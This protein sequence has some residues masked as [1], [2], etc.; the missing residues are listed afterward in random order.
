M[1]N[2]DYEIIQWFFTVICKHYYKLHRLQV[3]KQFCQRPGQ[4][5]YSNSQ[6]SHNLLVSLATS[7]RV[8]KAILIGRDRNSAINIV[9][10]RAV[11]CSVY[12]WASVSGALSC[13]LNATIPAA[14]ETIPPYTLTST[15]NFDQQNPD[16]GYMSIALDLGNDY[17]FS[18][19][20]D[21]LGVPSSCD[22][23]GDGVG[24]LK[25]GVSVLTGNSF[26]FS[27]AFP[28]VLINPSNNL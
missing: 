22:L 9:D 23:V 26:H 2:A 19:F 18:K 5:C 17:I 25:V 11:G 1:G 4:S 16:T 20:Y 15:I 12:R 8:L 28:G 24:G 27:H 3:T 14:L 6:H 7:V 21:V 10:V 13:Q